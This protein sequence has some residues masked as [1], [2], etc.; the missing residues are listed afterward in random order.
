MKSQKLFIFVKWQENQDV[1]LF[2]LTYSPH[3]RLTL[4]EPSPIAENDTYLFFF[5]TFIFE[6][7]KLDIRCESFSLRNLDIRCE[8]S[9]RENKT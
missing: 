5:F 9:A 4:T 7:I 8:S 3:R 2:Y 1:P 6:E